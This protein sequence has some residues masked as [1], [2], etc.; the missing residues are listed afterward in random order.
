MMCTIM[1]Q[2]ASCIY[3]LAPFVNDNS[4]HA[5]PIEQEK[6]IISSL[7]EVC[8]VYTKSLQVVGKY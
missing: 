4:M 7:K 5:E 2:A 8:N 1:R 3:G 6:E